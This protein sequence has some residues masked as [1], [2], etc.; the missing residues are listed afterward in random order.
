MSSRNV[1]TV[2]IE[3]QAKRQIRGTVRDE[4]GESII[5]ANVI[6]SET[7]N[8]TVTDVDGN[9]TLYVE[10]NAIIQVSYIGYVTLEVPVSNE[11]IINIV[12]TEN[13]QMI[14]EVVVVGYGVQRRKDL[15]GS[16]GSLKMDDLAGKQAV[17]VADYLMGSIAGLNISR[18][19][20]LTGQ[21]NMLIRGENSISAKIDPLLVVDGVIYPGG[22]N[23]I[24]AEDIEHIDVLKDASSAAVYGAKA[25]SGVIIITTK[26]GKSKKPLITVNSKFGVQTLL[27]KE[28]A[29]DVP[30]YLNMRTDAMRQYAPK[31]DMPG[32]YNNPGK[33]PQGVSL[34]QWLQYDGNVP[35]G[36][37]PIDYWLKRL[38]LY[39]DE[40]ANYHAGKSINWFD[41]IFQTGIMQDYNISMSGNTETFNYYWSVGSLYNKGVVYN[42]EYK[43]IRSRLNIEGKI[44]DFLKVGLNASLSN[45][46][47]GNPAANWS[48]VFVNSPLGNKYT[49][50]GVT[51]T[52]MP[53]GDNMAINPFDPC[54]YS[55]DRGGTSL[56]ATT[57]AKI[58]L[59]FDITYEMNF[60]NHWSWGQHYQY[61][62]ISSVEGG[63]LS[64][65]GFRNSTR[66][67]KWDI[68]NILRWEKVIANNH[69][70]NV[71]LLY[72]AEKYNDYSTQ[73]SSSNYE[74]SELL[75]YHA[76]GLGSVYQVSSNDET[77]TA[78]AMM[79]RLNYGFQD[80][81]LA[82]LSF[83]RD[84]YSAFGIN[85]PWA[86][87]YSTAL[88]WRLSEEK[89]LKE[90]DFLS[91]LKLRMSYGING[92]RDVGRY[93]ALSEL[94]NDNYIVNG[95]PVVSLYTLNMANPNLKWE[96]SA[97]YNLG[98]DFGFFNNR[99][100]GSVEA[101]TMQ[102]KDLLLT[103][104]LP[105]TTGYVSVISNMGQLDNEGLELTI[106]TL[107]IQKENLHWSTSFN[108][109]MNRNK[110]VH[111]YGDMIDIIDENGNV[112]G[113]READDSD[114][115]RYIGHALDAIYDYKVIG[116]WQEEEE[117][118]AK[119]YGKFPGDF[120]VLDRNDDGQFS[121]NE[122][123][124]WQGHRNP[125]YRFGMR[126]QLTLFKALDISCMVRANIGHVKNASGYAQSS[127]YTQRV[128]D[129][130]VPYWTPE[131]RSN[132][133]SRVR[134]TSIGATVFRS[135]SFL[136]IDDISIGYRL[137]EQIIKKMA[138]QTARISLN[139]D[140]VGC[141]DSWGR[142]DPET[143][144]P[145][146]VTFTL[147]INFTM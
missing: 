82:T 38:N 105:S 13:T 84:G 147:G 136:R 87:F 46:D 63:Q 114:N 71:T 108:F 98:I 27:R 2:Q 110:I 89:F 21:T 23:D 4:H 32:Y 34:E 104:A 120:K 31:D 101:Y 131:N 77:D 145:T 107:N 48:S 90:V 96:R 92:N 47:Y 5:G 106:N 33:L 137:P 52:K 135:A 7:T 88:A 74:V 44:N 75:G 11:S 109:S 61:R 133:Y 99:I 76:L 143:G 1:S 80:K 6:E 50:D 58:L 39:P 78:A 8:G 97:S 55:Q 123:K 59:P 41:E 17:S 134:P 117:E 116:V 53:N 124:V 9:F 29:Y 81:Y 86:N 12:L 49:E 69:R 16:V 132:T 62:P 36:V 30:G 25:A 79:A 22:L 67:H 83:R 70:F 60:T 45:Y 128:S 68:D 57:F 140:N 146:P 14:D 26:K 112:I 126:N 43:N 18:S 127:V 93:K 115:G 66:S 141:F 94:K 121:P 54:S 35:E 139:I 113:Q 111:L 73:A 3:Q 65:Y 130:V 122:D 118:D 72:N 119:K 28:K 56:F 85:N 20:S 91:N 42:D 138:I 129:Y 102:T 100:S 51:Y 64:G 10:E 19:A 40:I 103:R 15:T 24:N 142:W 144:E 95:T 37:N 125:R